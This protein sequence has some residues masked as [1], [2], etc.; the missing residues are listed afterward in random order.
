MEL[1]TNQPGLQFYSG[2][3][4]GAGPAGKGGSAYRQ[5]D[6]LALEPQLF[7]DTPNQPAFGN[8]ELIPGRI[9]RNRISYRFSTSH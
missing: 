2:N 6:A 4:L 1:W 9:Y 8:A 7:P 3:H 5:F